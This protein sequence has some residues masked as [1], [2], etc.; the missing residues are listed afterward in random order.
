MTKGFEAPDKGLVAMEKPLRVTNKVLDP[1]AKGF[2]ATNETFGD[3]EKGSG[4]AAKTWGTPNK[5]FGA[6]PKGFLAL[7]K[8]L[9]ATA[10]LFEM[11]KTAD[12][13]DRRGNED[14]AFPARIEDGGLRIAP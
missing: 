10:K 13:T 14:G 6:F 2:G 7:G 5:R 12:C 3:S 4:A 1:A 11:R 9:D 8:C